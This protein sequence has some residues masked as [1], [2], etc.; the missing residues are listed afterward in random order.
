MP[1]C[2]LELGDHRRVGAV[3]REREVMR[4]L[5]RV[6]DDRTEVAVHRAPARGRRGGVDGR[7]EQRMCEAHPAGRVDR[8]EARFLGCRES[9]RIDERGVRTR[10]RGNAKECVAR[11]RRQRSHPCADE[12]AEAVRHRQRRDGVLYAAAFELA[13][14]LDRVERIA[15]RSFG[16][17]NQDRPRKRPADD[18]ADDAVKCCDGHRSD[19]DALG[20]EPLELGRARTQ[21]EDH[22]HVLV[23]ESSQGELERGGG[24]W[25]Q[26][27]EVVDRDHDLSPGCE[28]PQQRQEC[29]GD[30]APRGR[31]GGVR[32]QE[33][34]VEP[35]ALGSGQ[36][37]E[38]LRRKS[39]REVGDAA[40]RQPGLRL[41]GP[42]DE[43]RRTACARS[44]NRLTPDRR[45]ADTGLTDDRKRLCRPVEKRLDCLQLRL[46]ANDARHTESVRRELSAGSCNREA[47]SVVHFRRAC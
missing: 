21:R 8:H 40:E 34:D 44:V 6:D 36:R 7:G 43:N 1:R 37:V 22:A 26:P 47:I 28:L 4:P 24:R 11:R 20:R 5:D 18:I 9:R 29:G 14:D 2:R 31:A 13:R 35:A 12:G 30:D 41:G 15:H 45:L 33:C 39:R 16:D 3:A 17:P 42:G 25:V 32:A 46:A 23:V 38:R 27:L 10:E 19:L